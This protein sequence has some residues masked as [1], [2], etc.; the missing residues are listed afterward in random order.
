MPKSTH[1]KQ[2]HQ[3]GSCTIKGFFALQEGSAHGKL[4]IGASPGAVKEALISEAPPHTVLPAHPESWQ[5]WGCLKALTP[6]WAPHG[7]VLC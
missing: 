1:T 6:A 2:T 5:G 3:G 4:K 7:C